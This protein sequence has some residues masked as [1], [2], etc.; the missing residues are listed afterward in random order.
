[1]A[2]SYEIFSKDPGTI[3]LELNQDDINITHVLGSGKGEYKLH[4]FY[5]SVSNLYGRAKS[6]VRSIQLIS[7][8]KE[9]DVAYFGYPRVCK[10][11]IKELQKLGE[12]GI[13]VRGRHFK[14]HVLLLTGDNVG[15]H[16]IGGLQ[17]NFSKAI[18][19]CRYCEVPR[20]VWLLKWGA[21]KE[22]A[23]DSDNESHCTDQ[24]KGSDD[25]RNKSSLSGSVN[26]FMDEPQIDTVDKGVT[27]SRR[28]GQLGIEVLDDYSSYM[29][30]RESYNL[31]IEQLSENPKGV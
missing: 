19:F 2:H 8:C 24:D 31:C 21:S 11:M 14:V 6:K 25:V 18:F 28:S 30:T 9:R 3:Q 4:A 16:S 5:Y 22:A 17:E 7:Y 27:E 26:E 15:T 12:K 20:D 29:R 10:P 1:M 13:T 23:C